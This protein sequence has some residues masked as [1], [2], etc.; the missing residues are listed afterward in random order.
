MFQVWVIQPSG[1]I[2]DPAI[3]DDAVGFA[4]FVAIADQF[5]R[6]SS[7]LSIAAFI[8]RSLTDANVSAGSA[9]R[10]RAVQKQVQMSV[11]NIHFVEMRDCFGEVVDI[12]AAAAVTGGDAPRSFLERQ[13]SA[14]IWAALF[15]TRVCPSTRR[16]V[17]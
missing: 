2:D 4:P 3:L 11:R 16:S 5:H 6:M 17:R 12:G 7:P 1:H 14:K 8:I 9:Y 15:T 10:V 13:A